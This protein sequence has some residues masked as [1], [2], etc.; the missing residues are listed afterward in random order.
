VT[1]LGLANRI[2]TVALGVIGSEGEHTI[3][4]QHAATRS[5]IEQGAG[6]DAIEKMVEQHSQA[7][8]MLKGGDFAAMFDEQ[9]RPLLGDAV[10]AP[11]Q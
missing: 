4:K 1:L 8:S 3:D 10:G 5:L 11:L 2:R 6:F 7:I 9:V